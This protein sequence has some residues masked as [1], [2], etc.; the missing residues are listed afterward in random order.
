MSDGPWRKT[1]DF[2]LFFKSESLAPPFYPRRAERTQKKK[3]VL[4]DLISLPD[5]REPW[6]SQPRYEAWTKLVW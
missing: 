4:S 5:E 3:N 2:F 1:D 6:F